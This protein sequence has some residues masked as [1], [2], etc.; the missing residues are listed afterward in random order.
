MMVLSA[1]GRALKV[2]GAL[3]LEQP[4]VVCLRLSGHTQRQMRH[5]SWPLMRVG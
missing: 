5:N 2:D 4:R 3:C 1:A